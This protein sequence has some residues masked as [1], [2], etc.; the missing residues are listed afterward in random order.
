KLWDMATWREIET[1]KGHAEGIWAVAFSPDGKTLITGSEDNTAKL[2][3]V[4]RGLESG[5]LGQ[6][7]SEVSS[8]AFSPDSKRL[9]IASNFS[10]MI[11]DVATGQPAR[12]FTEFPAIRCI[13][14]S[15][16]GKMIAAGHM[17]PDTIALRNTANDQRLVLEGHK[18]GV[19]SVA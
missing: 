16:D 18:D 10:L 3:D 17:G 5:A 4:N 6:H 19:L 9:A 12:S 8:I 7:Q 15:P 14:Y 2:W 13:A 11:W 1:I